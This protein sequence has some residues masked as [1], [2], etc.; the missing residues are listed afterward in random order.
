MSI[1]L[2]ACLNQYNYKIYLLQNVDNIKIHILLQIDIPKVDIWE[3]PMGISNHRNHRVTEALWDASRIKLFNSYNTTCL[4]GKRRYNPLANLHGFVNLTNKKRKTAKTPSNAGA[5]RN[6]CT[7]YHHH[8]LLKPT[9]RKTW[10][11]VL[12]RSHSLPCVGEPRC[13]QVNYSRTNIFICSFSNR[14]LRFMDA[15]RRGL[16]GHQAA[17]ASKQYRGHRTIPE[18]IL[19]ELEK[20]GIN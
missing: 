19:N 9:L 12:M 1:S 7:G 6:G 18:T 20:A 3:C 5:I 8:H 13:S 16:N 15:Y 11:D 2:G 4:M 10:S 17:W 14:T